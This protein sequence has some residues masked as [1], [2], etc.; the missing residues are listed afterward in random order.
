MLRAAFF[1]VVL[2]ICG[3]APAAAAESI[4][5][6]KAL[7]AAAAY[8]DALAALN[9]PDVEGRPVELHQYRVFCLVALG[10]Q[11]EAEKA[12]EALI[13]ADPL[14]VF[15]PVETSPRVQE[16]FNLRRQQLL[17]EIAKQFYFEA[18]S[19]LDRKDRPEAI[20][21]FER[22]VTIIDAA[23]GA[24]ASLTELRVLA[25]GFLDLSRAL[26]EPAPAPKVV[27]ETPSSSVP[28]APAAPVIETRPVALKQD[29]PPW[30]PVDPASRRM[31]YTGSVR[32]F[33]DPNGRV[34]DAG[35]VRGVHPNYD[36]ALLRA[37]R[38]WTYEPATRNGVPIGVDL[39]IE[40]NLR[41]PDSGRE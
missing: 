39:I 30:N 4:Q 36:G 24:S 21:R 17:P 33:V 29:L 13:S 28:S 8:E 31:A 1:C 25:S 19:A 9:S 34:T 10:R 38:T 40:V 23:K 16:A 15:D 7:Y 26:P 6:V 27:A 11:G 18:R 3:M 37:A 2:V 41:P 5:T 32:V 20:A 22:L 12:M 14:Y 35:I